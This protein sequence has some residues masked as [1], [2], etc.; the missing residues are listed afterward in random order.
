MSSASSRRACAEL[1]RRFGGHVAGGLGDA[2]L[3]YFGYPKRART[4]PGARPARRSRSHP[5][6]PVAAPRSRRAWKAAR[7][8][9]DRHSHRARGRARAA[10][11]RVRPVSVTSSLAPPRSWRPASASSP[12]RAAFSSATAPKSGSSGSSLL[13]RR[14]ASASRTTPRCRSRPSR[15][16][17][18]PPPAALREVPLVGRDREEIE[19]LLERWARASDG[20]GQAVLIAASRGSG[21]SR[22]A[23]A[24][25]ERIGARPH[26][27]IECRC[28][29]DSVH[30]AF[31]P[32]IELLDR[33]LDPRREA[34]PRGQGGQASRPCS[35]SMASSYA[36]RSRSS[37]PSSRSRCRSGGRRSTSRRRG[38][39]R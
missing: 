12:G 2:V 33:P 4:T 27:W 25:E 35:R 36:R 14:P 18:A 6:S 34:K 8:C 20:A 31:Y 10:R 39:A 3:F 29:P 37:R 16:A 21:K 26:A 23:R 5:R 9:P 22:L 19:A 24:L 13:A 17:T 15:C 11:S 32:I 28:T 38:S 1:A 7:R 30:S